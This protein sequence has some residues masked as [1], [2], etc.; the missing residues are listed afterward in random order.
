VLRASDRRAMYRKLTID[1]R[2][3][4]MRAAFTLASLD[5]APT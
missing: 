4:A 3:N 2:V 5:F 1:P